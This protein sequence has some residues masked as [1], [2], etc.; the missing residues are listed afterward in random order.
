MFH[1]SQAEC[2]LGMH[3]DMLPQTPAERT[4]IRFDQRPSTNLGKAHAIPPLYLRG[5]VVK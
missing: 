1:V 3:A 5:I 2:C 4:D